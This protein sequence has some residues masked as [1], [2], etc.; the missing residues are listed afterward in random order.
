MLLLYID[1][2][3]ST[4]TY[5]ARLAGEALDIN[6]DELFPDKDALESQRKALLLKFD[7]ALQDPLEAVLS[8]ESPRVRRK[9]A[10]VFFYMG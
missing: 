8:K 10:Q 1:V 9:L 6:L 5:S 7:R 3:L 4:P 2:Y